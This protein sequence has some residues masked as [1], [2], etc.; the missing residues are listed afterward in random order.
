MFFGEYI[1]CALSRLMIDGR[2]KQKTPALWQYTNPQE[3]LIPAPRSLAK[4]PSVH[5]CT[6]FASSLFE[7]SRFI[8][9]RVVCLT[10]AECSATSII[11]TDF[12][13]AKCRSHGVDKSCDFHVMPTCMHSCIKLTQ[14]FPS[15]V[16]I[17]MWNPLS[18]RLAL[19]E[20]LA[21]AK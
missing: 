3:G 19:S 11:I 13:Q 5:D 9:H 12:S 21:Q 17:P 16:E 1:R 15:C 8:L 2:A 18:R 6:A 7:V 4:G 14:L 20:H 10:S